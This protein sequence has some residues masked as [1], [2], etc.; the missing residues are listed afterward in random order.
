MGLCSQ[1]LDPNSYWYKI[2]KELRNQLGEF[3]DQTWLAGLIAQEN[4]ETKTLTLIAPTNF[5]RDYIQNHYSHKI[6]SCCEVNMT[7]KFIEVVTINS[8][9][10]LAT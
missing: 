9:R 3:V 6:R 5:I 2:R 1:E 7:M 10:V 4:L 8:L